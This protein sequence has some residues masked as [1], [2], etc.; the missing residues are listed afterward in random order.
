MKWFK[1]K[2]ADEFMKQVFDRCDALY[3]EAFEAYRAKEYKQ[4]I[5]PLLAYQF[6]WADCSMRREGSKEP[7]TEDSK[8]DIIN[9][10][11]FDP[12]WD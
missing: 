2:T 10:V 5:I 11:G 1:D 7:K 3:N 8:K 6:G 9:D 4:D 12:N